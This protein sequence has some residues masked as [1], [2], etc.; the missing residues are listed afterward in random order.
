MSATNYIIDIALIAIVLR[1]LVARQLTARS[2]LLPVVLVALAGLNYLKGFPTAGNDLPLILILIAIGAVLGVMSGTT[3]R[4][5]NQQGT[6]WAKAGIVAAS[7]WVLGMGFRM[8]FDIWANTHD[9]EASLY[10]FSIHHSITS[11]QAFTTAFVLM[12]F[13]QVFSRV[14]IL[15]YRRLRLEKTAGKPVVSSPSS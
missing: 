2:V 4:L 14:G 1:Q 13:A 12:A 10:R 11:A 15:Q 3:T 6:V 5:W 9:G 8:G 7:V